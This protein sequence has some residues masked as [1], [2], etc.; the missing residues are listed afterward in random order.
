MNTQDTLNIFLILALFI[1]TACIVYVTL[2]FARALKSVT[3][4]TDDL[5]EI[6]Q[7]IK[8][9]VRL[10]VLAA[11][12]ALLVALVGKVIKKKRG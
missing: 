1:I 9:K 7:G 3:Q 4:L 8:D 2:Y 6:T 5:D 11:I 10:K 12:P